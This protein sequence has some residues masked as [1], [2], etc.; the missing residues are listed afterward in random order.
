[1]QQS[2]RKTDDKKLRSDVIYSPPMIKI[3]FLAHRWLCVLESDLPLLVMVR[4]PERPAAVELDVELIS[5]VA[6]AIDVDA[7]A[8]IRISWKRSLQVNGL[9]P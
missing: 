9:R 4:S 7:I 2:H 6:S 1:M 3:I 8:V 5:V